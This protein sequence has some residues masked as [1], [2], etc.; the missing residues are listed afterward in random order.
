M[1]VFTSIQHPVSTVYSKY[2][3]FFII[4]PNI[5]PCADGATIMLAK[6]EC[7]CGL[8]IKS[9]SIQFGTDERSLNEIDPETHNLLVFSAVGKR[10]G[11]STKI[12][13]GDGPPIYIDSSLAEARC[14]V[15]Q[16]SVEIEFDHEMG[17]MIGRIQPILILTWLVSQEQRWE[18]R[19]YYPQIGCHLTYSRK[20]GQSADGVRVGPIL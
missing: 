19:I 20:E 17:V 6:I 4:I 8:P 7:Q 16:M 2:A 12:L 14:N 1:N 15:Y 10:R 13:W 5:P 18:P 3:K 11:T 9:A